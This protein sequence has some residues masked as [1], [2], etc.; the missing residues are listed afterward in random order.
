MIRPQTRARTKLL[1]FPHVNSGSAAIMDEEAGNGP[2]GVF[3]TDSSGF[4]SPKI[5]GMSS[6]TVGWICIARWST[7]Y[8]DFEYMT[9]RM[10]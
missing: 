2:D 3:Q 10:Q 7:V 1:I 6:D 4:N 8:G 5:V 9:S